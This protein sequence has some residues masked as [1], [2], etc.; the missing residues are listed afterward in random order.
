MT[1]ISTSSRVRIT[2]ITTTS[3]CQKNHPLRPLAG[4]KCHGIGPIS[5]LQPKQTPPQPNSPSTPS[6]PRLNSSN[7]HKN[8]SKL[9]YRRR[10]ITTVFA[11]LATVCLSLSI[12]RLLL[13]PPTS[14]WLTE[15]LPPSRPHH[16]HPTLPL[17]AASNLSGPLLRN[18]GPDMS[19]PRHRHHPRK[20][21]FHPSLL[22]IPR[23]LHRSA[24]ITKIPRT[25]IA[26]RKCL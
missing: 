9:S 21:H 24:R 13:S 17:L 2:T 7:K 16:R 22:R 4:M 25:P 1:S 8:T 11:Y 5:H 15:T 20:P 19:L 14:Q 26:S 3:K 12:L 6:G 10:R 23:R 18:L